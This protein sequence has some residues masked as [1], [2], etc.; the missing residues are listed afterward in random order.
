MG[1]KRG[2]IKSMTNAKLVLMMAAVLI[3]GLLTAGAGVMGHSAIR[4]ENPPRAGN[5]G[6][7]PRQEVAPSQV[8]Q[9]PPRPAGTKPA[10]DQ[11]PVM[12]QAE[13]V[14]PEGRRLTRSVSEGCRK[15]LAARRQ[16]P[17]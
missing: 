12:I 4:Q 6:Q 10:T 3:A 11:G 8:G 14:D 15:S 7:E 1:E 13:V 9:D 5:P 16:R 2:I 17:R